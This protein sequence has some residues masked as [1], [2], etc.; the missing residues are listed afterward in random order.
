MVRRQGLQAAILHRPTN[1][2]MIERLN[3]QAL[4]ADDLMDRIIE[5]AAD[6]RRAHSCRF[7]FQ[8]QDLAEQSCFPKHAWIPPGAS[9]PQ[10]PLELGQHAE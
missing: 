6:A 3:G 7:R 2:K 9:L 5:E 10:D 4:N 1:R 8:I